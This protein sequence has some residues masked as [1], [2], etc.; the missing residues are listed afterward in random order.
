M[1]NGWTGGQYSLYRAIFGTYLLVHFVH[2]TGWGPELFSS[3]GVLADASASPL[4]YLFPNILTFVDAP[5]FVVALLVLGAALSVAFAIGWHDR[6]AAVGLWYLWAC[7]LGRNPLISNPGIPY[8]GWLLL[9]HAFISP[10]P[11]GSMAARRRIDP[12]G[13]WKLPSAIFAV[14]WSLMALGYTY[15][16]YTKLVSPS[17]IDGSA[18]VRVLENPLARPHFLREWLLMLPDGLLR[19]ATW[20]GLALE[21]LFLPLALFR[22]VRPWLWLAMVLMHCSL[23]A[24]V[25]FADLTLSMLMLHLFTFDPAWIRPVAAAATDRLFYDGTCGMCHGSV[26]LLLA[27]DRSGSAFRFAP[28]KGEAFGAALPAASSR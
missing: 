16:G 27:E 3:G 24:L 26:R 18:L 20:G 14:A 28:L 9:A 8:V 6:I 12:G 19:L 7:L 22:R 2:L 17:W 23:I 15:S 21:L 13:G 25:D 5:G 4:A 11:F 10:P 1:S